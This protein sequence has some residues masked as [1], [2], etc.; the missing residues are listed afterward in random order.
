MWRLASQPGQ[1]HRGDLAGWG[2][3][4]PAGDPPVG[5]TG[6]V[7]AGRGDHIAATTPPVHPLEVA[8]ALLVV[9]GDNPGRLRSEAAFSMLCGSSPLEASSGKT[10][11]H[12]L[13]RG[14]DRAANNALWTIAFVRLIHD[15]RTRAYAA[16]RTAQ[17]SS[18]KEILRCLKRTIARELYPLILEALTVPEPA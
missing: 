7:A 10:V 5:V 12:R 1:Q 14:G 6:G 16:K 18:R 17:G 8:G 4:V 13:N 15:P 9:A 11:R 2:I 3:E